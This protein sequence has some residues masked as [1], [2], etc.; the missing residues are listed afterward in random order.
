MRLLADENLERRVVEALTAAGH[1][2]ACVHPRMCGSGDDF[3]LAWATSEKRVVVTDDK[4]FGELVTRHQRPA[5]AVL[6]LRLDDM[7]VLDKATY[8]CDLL[9]LLEHRIPG[10]LA[11]VTE[12]RVRLRPL[13]PVAA[14]DVHPRRQG[15]P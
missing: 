15:S 10:H 9:S 6:L 4:D 7:D 8:L 13:G 2:V 11:V 3:I 14:I 12:H 1:D 5:Y